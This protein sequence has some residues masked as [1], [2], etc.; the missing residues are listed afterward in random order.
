MAGHPA[1]KSQFKTAEGRYAL[2]SEKTIGLVPFAMRRTTR[3]TIATLHGGDEEGMYMVYNVGDYLHVAPFD[4]TD[5]DPV[6]SLIFNPSAVRDGHPSCHAYYPTKDGLDLLVGFANGEIALMSLRAQLQAPPGNTRPI[7]AATLNADQMH[8]S[9]RCNAVLWAPRS[10][11]SQFLAC[12]ASGSILVYKKNPGMTGEGSG[13]LLSHLSSKS[14]G[15]NPSST[16]SLACGGINDAAFCPDGGRLA[17]ACRDGSV[18]LLEWPSGACLGGYQSYYGAAL[19]VCWSPDAALLASG[20]EDDLVTVYSVADR[21]VVAF[22]EG[23]ASWVSRVA[24]DPWLCTTSSSS[25]PGCQVQERFYRLGSVGQDTNLCL[26]DLVI[27][28]DPAVNAATGQTGGLKRVASQSQVNIPTVSSSAN[29]AAHQQQHHPQPEQQAA[30]APG[31]SRSTS[32]GALAGVGTG[33]ASS[34]GN[35][36]NRTASGNLL[37]LLKQQPH[38]PAAGAAPQQAAPVALSLPRREMTMLPPVM[39]HRIHVEP[40]SEMLFTE[41]AIFT[42]CCSGQIKCWLR[43]GLLSSEEPS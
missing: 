21:Q 26:W 40:V 13:K 1:V 6:C 27:E 42:G 20:G 39:Q 30:A 15:S 25:G 18:R 37:S 17:V 28:E 14:T 41:E 22:G 35:S 7:I 8:D 11:G 2:H 19:C 43:P 29:L 33:I 32:D 12:H 9:S 23:H 10:N 36:S 3:L 4:A 34:S 24:F 5:K 31:H 38:Q 16:I